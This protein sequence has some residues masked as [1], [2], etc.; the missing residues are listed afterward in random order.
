MK[1]VAVILLLVWAVETWR[2]FE[3]DN[4]GGP[5]R[6][7]NPGPPGAEDPQG[8]MDVGFG[9]N[10]PGGDYVVVVRSRYNDDEFHDPPQVRD[11]EAAVQ[12]LP[13]TFDP[14]MTYTLSA[15]VGRLP[16]GAAEGGSVNYTPSWYGYGLQLA[17]GGTQIMVDAI[18]R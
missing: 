9:G 16:S 18:K 7:W 3:S 5:L 11:F 17:V 12:L 10:A 15:Q 8:A 13:E 1:W 2:H 6:I 14:T 4:N